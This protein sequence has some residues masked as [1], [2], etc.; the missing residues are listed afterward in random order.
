MAVCLAFSAALVCAQDAPYVDGQVL[1]KFRPAAT[2]ENVRLAVSDHGFSIAQRFGELSAWRGQEYALIKS[3]TKNT[4]ELIAELQNDPTV[5]DVAPDYLKK[6]AA[7]PNDPYWPKLWALNNTGQVVNGVAGISGAD[8][9]WPSAWALSRPDGTT[10]VV[11]VIDTGVNYL[12]PD[13]VSNMWVNTGEI[14]NNAIDDDHN[15]YTN[16]YY[17]Y[18]FVGNA[19]VPPNPSPMDNNT[20]PGHGTHVAGIIAATGNNGIG[21]VGVNPRAQIMALKISTDGEYVVTSAAIAAMEYASRLKTNGVN[22][23]AINESYYS[24]SN[25]P[26]EQDEI[27]HVGALGIIVCASAG[28]GMGGSNVGTNNDVI[29]EYPA[30]YTCSNIIA[31][32]AS[33]KND[34]LSSFS[35]YGS[36]SVDLC[37]PG[38]DIYST[39]V[40]GHEGYV[41]SGT[42]NY[43]ALGLLYAGTTTGITARLYNCGFGYTNNFPAA[44]SGNVALIER[45][46]NTFVQMVANAM[47]AHARA[48]IVYNNKTNS[49]SWTLDTTTNWIPAVAMTM[50]DGQ[51]LAAAGTPTVTVVNALSLYASEEGTSMSAGY[52]SGA[53]ALM[54]MNF[55]TENVTT[56]IARILSNVD[57]IP[58][59]A[60]KVHSGGRLNLLKATDTDS[61]GLPDWWE[62]TYTN[63]L[64]A[65]NGTTDTD[66]DGFSDLYEFL[67]G[68]DPTDSNS[69]LRL[70]SVLK[71]AYTGGVGMVIQWPSVTGRTYSVSRI[72]NIF[73]TASYSLTSGVA[74]TP[75]VNVYTDQSSTSTVSFYDINLQVQ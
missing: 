18:D 55:P 64:T 1:V 53:V 27:S 50:Q 42:S 31:V 40:T 73:T 37:A 7:V 21:V 29:P 48:A 65:M 56:R 23:V 35:D 44:V 58:S 47:M 60:G 69:F 24:T 9:K 19:G 16:D 12:H 71:T 54:A 20:V 67:A 70:N 15:G 75:P 5:E 30:S 36:N 2:R 11:A 52:V 6:L 8:I 14:T 3:D 72:T 49:L 46:S 22:V 68:T 32:A 26:A 33:D 38:V 28:N 43:F 59:L 61:D 4:R 62:L 74:A 13:L 41:L 66:K 25:S 34:G 10:V 45:G 39:A 17:G 51:T 63:N 57:A